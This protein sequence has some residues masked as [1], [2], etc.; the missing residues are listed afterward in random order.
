MEWFFRTAGIINNGLFCL[1]SFTQLSWQRHLRWPM[2]TGIDALSI[3][4]PT[5]SSE[6]HLQYAEVRLVDIAIG[7]KVG[8]F[9]VRVRKGDRRRR[10]KGVGIGKSIMSEYR[11]DSR[12]DVSIAGERLLGAALSCRGCR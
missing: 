10:P 4:G 5:G 3:A 6:S 2:A 12:K 1:L 8:H 9:A 7:V 11:R